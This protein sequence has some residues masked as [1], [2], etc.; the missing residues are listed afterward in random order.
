MRLLDPPLAPEVY[1]GNRHN[2]TTR[3]LSAL[4]TTPSV[5]AFGFHT[6][7]PSIESSI[8]KSDAPLAATR[9]D[10]RRTGTLP[11]LVISKPVSTITAARS[12]VEMPHTASVAWPSKLKKLP[13]SLWAEA[14][15]RTKHAYY[16]WENHRARKRWDKYMKREEK[17]CKVATEHETTQDLGPV[18]V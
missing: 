12:R 18:L 7:A 8:S 16:L 6:R 14:S 17:E 3:P 13:K 5:D 10:D 1:A 4:N 9:S 11:D 15:R 2:R